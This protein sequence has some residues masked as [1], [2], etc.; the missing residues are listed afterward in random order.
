MNGRGRWNHL[1]PLRRRF[2]R[3]VTRLLGPCW[4]WLGALNPKG[5]GTLGKRL[6]TRLSWELNRGAIPRGKCVLH[7]CDNP[8][9]VRP[10]HLFLGTHAENMRDMA[11]KER[12]RTTKLTWTK[13]A[14]I[15]ASKETGP[16][17]ARRYKVSRQTIGQIRR[18]E[19]WRNS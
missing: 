19:T 11:K 16:R 17:L 5:Y 18:H 9:C 14:A 4:I 6:A 3:K 12:S 8:A 2:N 1:E 13:V 7:T 10:A 15:R